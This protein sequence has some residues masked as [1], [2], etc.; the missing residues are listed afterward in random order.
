MALHDAL[1]RADERAAGLDA[2]L[3][4]PLARGVR[5]DD[6]TAGRLAEVLEEPAVIPLTDIGER[7]HDGRRAQGPS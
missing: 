6:L 5:A 1:D 4:R 3:Q 7:G 2:G